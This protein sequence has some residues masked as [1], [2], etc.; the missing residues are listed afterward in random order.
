[1]P[2]DRLTYNLVAHRSPVRIRFLDKLHHHQRRL[3]M[4]VDVHS[5]HL[6]GCS[7]MSEVGGRLEVPADCQNAASD[8][9]ETSVTHFPLLA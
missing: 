1:M 7:D 8:P 5:R 9:H 3:L 4:S 6:V 2:L